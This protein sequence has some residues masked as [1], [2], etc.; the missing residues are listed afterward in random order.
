VTKDV[1]SLAFFCVE[2]LLS[3][4]CD[5]VVGWGVRDEEKSLL[6]GLFFIVMVFRWQR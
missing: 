3:C 5:C 2:L 4:R 1:T 6:D